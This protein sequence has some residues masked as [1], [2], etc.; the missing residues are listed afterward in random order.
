MPIRYLYKCLIND[1]KD[2]F[3]FHSWQ[4]VYVDYKPQRIKVAQLRC[5][6]DDG[7]LLEGTEQ[8]CLKPHPSRV[9]ESAS[10][11][12]VQPPWPSYSPALAPAVIANGW[13]SDIQYESVVYAGMRHSRM[14][15]HGSRRAGYFI[16][17][18]TGTGK[19]PSAPEHTHTRT[20]T[21]THIHMHPPT[22]THTTIPSPPQA[23]K[24]PPSS[25]I[26]G[27]EVGGAACG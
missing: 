25:W 13:L 10:F 23:V 1:P 3:T 19:G 5:F 14:L 4:Q 2:L 21:H 7:V 12:A 16:G 11:S 9:V 22:P 18:G 24:S 26:I 20:H 8:V 27:T 15:E 17:D 6:D